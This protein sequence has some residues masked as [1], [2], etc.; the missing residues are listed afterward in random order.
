MVKHSQKW[1][2]GASNRRT[3]NF[4]SDGKA[5]ITNTL[6]N[7]GRDMKKLKENIHAI[8]VSCKNCEEMHLDKECPLKEEIKRAE[9]VKYGEFGIGGNGSRYRVGPPRYYIRVENHPLFGEKKPSLEETIKKHI[10][11]STKRR[12]ETKEWM[13]KL[14]EN[15]DMKIRNQNA[16]LKNLET[17]IEQLTKDF[18]AKVA[19]EARALL[20]P[21]FIA[22]PYS[23]PCQLTLKELNPISFTL[24]CIIGSLNIYVLADLGASVN[25][26]SFSMFKSLELTNLKETTKLVEM[27]DMSKKAPRG[28]IEKILVL[29]TKRKGKTKTYEPGTVKWKLHSYEAT[30][31]RKYVEW[32]IHNYKHPQN[33]YARKKG[34]ASEKVMMYS[35]QENYVVTT[36][37]IEDLERNGYPFDNAQINQPPDWRTSRPA[38]YGHL[39][40]LY[41]EAP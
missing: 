21:L 41:L 14:Q 32:S 36:L 29:I 24:L 40:H 13:R 31:E 5:A 33:P 22:R 10:E 37:G 17:Q 34:S 7:L 9:E 15:T 27:A 26:M 11:E 8:Q 38:R 23:M 4:N 18:Q 1:H 6:D 16:A 20:P 39:L 30:R 12:V 28:I 35:H 25:I 19:K 3:S 2:D